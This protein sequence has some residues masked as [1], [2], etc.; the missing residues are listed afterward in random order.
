MILTASRVLADEYALN[1][2]NP[3]IS[4]IAIVIL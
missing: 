4:E 2:Q 1:Y 3:V